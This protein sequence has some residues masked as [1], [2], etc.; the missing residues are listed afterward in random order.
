MARRVGSASAEKVNPRESIRTSIA[1]WLYCHMAI[2]VSR[3]KRIRYEANPPNFAVAL[4]RGIGLSS[5]KADVKALDRLQIVLGLN[6]SYF[7]SK[8]YVV[9]NIILL[10]WRRYLCGARFG[11]GV[12]ARGSARRMAT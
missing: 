12:G 7:G 2:Y 11:M 9:D 1:M 5:L 4:N 6:S 10:M 8:Y 3:K